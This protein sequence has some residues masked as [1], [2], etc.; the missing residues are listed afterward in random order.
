MTKYLLFCF[1]LLTFWSCKETPA[2]PVTPGDPNNPPKYT[3]SDL[4]KLRWIEGNWRSDVEGPGFYQLYTFSSDTSL[5]ILSYQFNGTD[6]SANTLN[7]VYWTNDHIYL[8][9]YKEWV[10]VLLT[11]N[12]IQL[13][14][15][16][17]GWHTIS[18][19]FDEKKGT[20]VAEHKRP[21]FVRTIK[22]KRHAPLE[23]MLKK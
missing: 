12:A 11:E 14:P 20:W 15:T 3:K 18:W 17:P 16:R 23:E 5:N 10:A 6:T 21:D 19:T 8:G 7:T 1:A 9:P 22:M 13:S 4:K 2:A